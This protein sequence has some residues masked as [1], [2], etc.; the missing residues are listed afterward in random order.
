MAKYKVEDIRNLALVGHGA[1][2]KTSLADALLSK[3]GAVDR[4]G[5]VDD[6]TSV[7]DYDDEEKK[8]H[9]SIDTSV[10][11]L[12]SQG[13]PVNLLDAPGY[14]DFVGGALEA[15]NAVE[16]ALIVISAPSGIEVNTRR[17]FA[18]AG[19][20]G[21]ARMLVVNKLDAE[22]IRFNDLLKN[23]SDTFGKGCVL[24]NAPN[25][26]GPAFSGV[27]SVLHP[28]DSA[29]AAV[30]I[31]AARSKLVDAIVESDDALMEKY[32]MEGNVS[33]DELNAAIPK[34][35]AAGTV[36]P[37]LCTSAKKDIGIAELLEAI[38]R[39]ALSP[40]QRQKRTAVKG[41]GE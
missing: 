39:Y 30:D 35:L 24:F 20:R 17:M 10:L 9:F 13:K 19:R 21:L 1:A 33:A 41:S 40:L 23:I 6:G 5:S 15:L 27:V 22:N 32:L 34:A 37:I 7:S 36:I 29:K 28:P 11:H 16:T 38:T 12:E 26:V 31:A 14:P 8:R 2:G 3:A 18:E 4:R 25:A